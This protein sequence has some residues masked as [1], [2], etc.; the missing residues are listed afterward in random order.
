MYT[1]KNWNQYTQNIQHQ[2]N[3]ILLDLWDLVNLIDVTALNFFG[4]IVGATKN[5]TWSASN[6]TILVVS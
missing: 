5:S 1:A 2:K 4:Q 3:P 6:F